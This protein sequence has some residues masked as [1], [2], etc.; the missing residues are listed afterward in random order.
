M[1][2]RRQRERCRC[3]PWVCGGRPGK[4]R[5]LRGG[6]FNN[7]QRNVRC[8][9]RNR[10]NP[11][12]RNNNIGFRVV[13]SHESLCGAGSAAWSRLG[14]RGPAEGEPAWP[15]PGRWCGQS[16]DQRANIE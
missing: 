10:N 5:V 11:D 16:P 3:D 1:V 4:R 9:Y 14:G 12:N 7:N 13:V 2:G 6:S 15:V 8:A